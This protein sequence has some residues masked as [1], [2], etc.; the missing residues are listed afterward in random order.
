MYFETIT[1]D[2]ELLFNSFTFRIHSIMKQCKVVPK[3]HPN[4]QYEFN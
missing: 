4:T 3:Y 2:D 1:M